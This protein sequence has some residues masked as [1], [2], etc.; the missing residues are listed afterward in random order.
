MTECSICGLPMLHPDGL[1]VDGQLVHC[2][3]GHVAMVSCDETSLFIG[4]AEYASVQLR[5]LVRAVKGKDLKADI[6]SLSKAVKALE[7]KVSRG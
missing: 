1:Y 5:E 6:R 4:D 3:D 7:K 2:A